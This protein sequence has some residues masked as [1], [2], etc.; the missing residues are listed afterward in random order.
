[1]KDTTIIAFA[2]KIF[3]NIETM[4]GRAMVLNMFPFLLKILPQYV[5]DNFFGVIRLKSSRDEFYSFIEVSN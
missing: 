3:G 2:E 5:I 1:M 4:Q